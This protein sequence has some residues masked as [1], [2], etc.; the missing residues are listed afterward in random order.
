VLGGCISFTW[1][2][3]SSIWQG[4][5]FFPSSRHQVRARLSFCPLSLFRLSYGTPQG[6][7]TFNADC[8]PIV[9]PNTLHEGLKEGNG[10]GAI[11]ERKR[12]RARGREASCLALPCT[13]HVLRLVYVSVYEIVS[14][15][16]RIHTYRGRAL[17][18]L[19]CANRQQEWVVS[20]RV[21]TF[22]Q[23]VEGDPL[24]GLEAADKAWSWLRSDAFTV[25][26][27]TPAVATCPQQTAPP[28]GPDF[29]CAC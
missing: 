1:T 23:G 5:P 26:P 12:E 4:T 10:G 20:E 3:R 15:Y 21:R 11:K 25:P 22:L 24:K 14:V 19:S 28:P 18:G 29:V 6:I 8:M 2:P 9:A 7:A 16:V 17:T 13:F 27:P